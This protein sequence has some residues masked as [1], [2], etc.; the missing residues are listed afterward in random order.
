VTALFTAD[1]GVIT[2]FTMACTGLYLGFLS[3][4]QVYEA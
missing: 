2:S 1:A 4:I 3:A